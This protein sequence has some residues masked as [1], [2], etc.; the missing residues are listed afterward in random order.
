MLS[1]N[2]VTTNVIDP[3]MTLQEIAGYL[4]VS[5]KTILRMVQAGELPGVKVSNQWRFVRGVVDDWL[6]QRMFAAPKKSFLGMLNTAP[7]IIPITRLVSPP[8]IIL[9]LAP[10]SKEAIL[11][12]LVATLLEDSLVTDSDDY[13]GRLLAREETVSTGIGHGLAIPHVRDPERCA[14]A[15]PC[16]VIGI[17]REGA[18]FG[19][20]D[21]QKTFVFAMPCS[22]SEQNHLRLLAK[23]ALLFRKPGVLAQMTGARTK[24]EIMEIL[25]VAD[26]ELMRVDFD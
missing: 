9:D 16:I 23:I 13:V 18:D 12:Q 19:A 8:R 3:I 20:L 17:C 24:K 2:V 10:G 15:L 21:G 4:K 22:S 26:H 25:A 5:E 14:I 11:K 6:G 7:H 1:E